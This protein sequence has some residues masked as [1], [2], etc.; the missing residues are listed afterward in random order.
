MKYSKKQAN[1]IYRNLK[2]GEVSY[3]RNLT[4]MLYDGIDGAASDDFAIWVVDTVNDIFQN[5]GKNF[6]GN[7][8]LAATVFCG[9]FGCNS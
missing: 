1:V 2:Q 3:P 8:K 5:S 7:V 9:A 4:T 6:A